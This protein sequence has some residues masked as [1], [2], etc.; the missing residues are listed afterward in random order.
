MEKGFGKCV[1]SLACVMLTMLCSL[2]DQVVMYGNSN[3][4][5]GS[6]YIHMVA[7]AIRLMTSLTFVGF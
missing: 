5:S 1:G 3:L 6:L 4:L 7:A 2:F